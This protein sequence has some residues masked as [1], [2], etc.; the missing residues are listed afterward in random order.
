MAPRR[1]SAARL[2]AI[3][4]V[5]LGLVLWMLGDIVLP[6]VV[7]A[8]LAYALNPL[9]D[10]LVR[11]GL[12]RGGAVALVAGGALGGLALAVVAVIPVL[13]SE[14]AALVEAAPAVFGA[15]AATLTERFPDLTLDEDAL[16]QALAR[17]GNWAQAQ[18]GAIANQLLSSARSLVSVVLFVVV[19]PVVTV[20]LLADWPRMLATV[21]AL[22]PRPQAPT[23]RDLARRIDRAVAAYVRGMGAVCLVMAGWYGFG[24]MLAGLQFGLLVGALAGILTFIP[25]VGAVVGGVLAI[26]LG[27]WQ[28]WGDWVPLG[29]VLA[30]FLIGQTVESNI[31]TPRIIGQAVGLHP[32][33]LLFALSVMGTLF[34]LV[35]MLVAVP[36][37]AAAGVLVR[38]G[39]DLYRASSLFAGEDPDN[40][41]GSA[42]QTGPD[43]P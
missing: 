27:L 23:I 43:K 7:G 17:M 15:L 14:A 40:S 30:V 34:G 18:G 31:V 9:V 33:W 4:A 24:F 12:P 10:A 38:H 35:G 8:G 39:L 21:D 19:V 16:R 13:I 36:M 25:Y 2:W 29:L 26:G 20:Y 42:S 5:A 11:R 6:F 28:F 41:S 3:A 32:V 1:A 22:I 37:A